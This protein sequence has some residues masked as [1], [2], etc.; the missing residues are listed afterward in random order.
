MQTG[1]KQISMALWLVLGLNTASAETSLMPN[2]LTQTMAALGWMNAQASVW[3]AKLDTDPDQPEDLLLLIHTLSFAAVRPCD[4]DLYLHLDANDKLSFSMS[5]NDWQVPV[6]H[7][8]Q[9]DR[10]IDD[11]AQQLADTLRQ[12]NINA[13][14]QGR[15][16]EHT[17]PYW[18]FFEKIST[19]R[20]APRHGQAE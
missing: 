3:R 2:Q 16:I 13:W 17:M 15:D 5:H 1:L 11:Q 7:G 20:C 18:R 14:N 4:T 19:A 10:V 6:I 9:Y 12:R 8:L